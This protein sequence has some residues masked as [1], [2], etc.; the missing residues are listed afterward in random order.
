MAKNYK[1]TQRNN[2]GAISFSHEWNA[3]FFAQN[4]AG[5]TGAKSTVNPYKIR[6]SLDF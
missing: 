1:R 5:K 6:I 2:A 4:Q 3:S